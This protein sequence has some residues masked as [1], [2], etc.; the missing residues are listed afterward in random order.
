MQPRQVQQ[1]EV[2]RFQPQRRPRQ[3]RKERYDGG[4]DHQRQVDMV[5]ADPDQDQGRDGDH[6]RHLQDDGIGIERALQQP[7]L[8]EA[9]GGDDTQHR[10]GGKSLQCHRQSGRQRLDQRCEIL[11]QRMGDGGGRGQHIMRHLP[12][13]DGPFPRA[14]NQRGQRKWKQNVRCVLHAATAPF[15][16]ALMVRWA[17]MVAG[18]SRPS[19]IPG[20]AMSAVMRPGRGVITSTR[21]ER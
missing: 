18:A 2:R 16:A 17:S 3:D 10:R 21:R 8:G 14:Q 12:V 11:A 5:E 13:M 7:A 9:D 1:V 19:R 4:D 20:R 15:S 6:R